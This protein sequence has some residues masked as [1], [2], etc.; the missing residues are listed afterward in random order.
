[1][2]HT[3]RYMRT[4]RCVVV[5]ESFLEKLMYRMVRG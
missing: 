3:E 4:W 1:M 2:R 5:K